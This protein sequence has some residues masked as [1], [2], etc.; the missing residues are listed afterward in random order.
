MLKLLF[1]TVVDT[2]SIPVDATIDTGKR[3]VDQKHNFD[4]TDK[5]IKKLKEDL[6]DLE[7]DIFY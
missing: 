7:D 1:K 6:K 4:R 2:L 5:R 3:I